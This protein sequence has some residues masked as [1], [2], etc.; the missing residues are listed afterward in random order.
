MAKIQSG[1][2]NLMEKD[3][4]KHGHDIRDKEKS[5]QI[6]QED[7]KTFYSCREC[8]K[9]SVE[10]YHTNK[11]LGLGGNRTLKNKLLREIIAI[12]GEFDEVTLMKIL[13]KFTEGSGK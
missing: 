13:V 8:L 10:R 1:V 5:V 11:S 6:R 9:K 4:C 12:L 2:P 7:T 3:F